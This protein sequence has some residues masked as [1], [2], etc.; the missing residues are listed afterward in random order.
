MAEEKHDWIF[1]NG[2]DGDVLPNQDPVTFGAYAGAPSYRLT[3]EEAQEMA[4]EL[5][6]RNPGY[7]VSAMRLSEGEC[8]QA[9]NG[10]FVDR[11]GKP[12]SGLRKPLQ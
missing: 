6:E 9:L 1:V 2:C 3:R 11:F 8:V 7:L 5:A 12:I 10:A 4:L